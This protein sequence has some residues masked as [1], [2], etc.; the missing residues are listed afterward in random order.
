MSDAFDYKIIS[1][2]PELSAARLAEIIRAARRSQP[3]N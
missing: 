2:V 1:D 3:T